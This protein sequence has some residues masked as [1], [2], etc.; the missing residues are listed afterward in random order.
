MNN[1]HHLKKKKR[2]AQNNGSHSS[3]EQKSLIALLWNRKCCHLRQIS[4][5]FN[6]M[7]SKVL[8]I[9]LTVYSAKWK[10]NAVSVQEPRK[11][12]FPLISYNLK[13]THSKEGRGSW[14][15]G[16]GLASRGRGGKRQRFSSN[17]YLVGVLLES[18]LVCS[19]IIPWVLYPSISPQVRTPAQRIRR[20][21]SVRLVMASCQRQL[22]GS[23]RID[24]RSFPY[25]NCDLIPLSGA[26]DMYLNAMLPYYTKNDLLKFW[27]P[28]PDQPL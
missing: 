10:K 2:K 27:I 16:G 22:I 12:T 4:K 11:K 26:F 14:G 20:R 15:R 21:C 6:W 5:N 3:T 28:V 13:S 1:W 9:L 7:L 18:W 17:E 23:S 8:S 19:S 25:L 24:P